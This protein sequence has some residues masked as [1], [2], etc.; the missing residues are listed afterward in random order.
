VAENSAAG[1]LVGRVAA[2]DPDANSTLTYTL[3]NDAGGRFDINSAT[4][5]VTVKAGA[6][7]DFEAAA[8]HSIR[9]EAKDAGGSAAFA[10]L[11]VKVGNVNEAPTI[12]SSAAAGYSEN[13]TTAVYQAAAID[14]E[15]ATLTWS[16][17]GAD[18]SLFTIGANGA[19]SFKA[20]PNFEAPADAGG[21]NV[22]D[23]VVNA[24][25]GVNTAQK[26]V[27]ISVTNVN[28][29]PSV[30]SGASASFAEN[31]SGVVYQG[32]AVDPDSGSSLSWSLSGADAS[33]FAI[34]AA[35]GQVTFKSPPNFEMPADQG[36]NNIY[37]VVVTASDGSLGGSQAVQISVTNVNEAPSA[38]SWAVSGLVAENAASGS[39]VGRATS[40]DPDAAQTLSYTLVNNAGG[41]FVIN[42]VTG[43][44]SVAAGASFDFETATSH[45]IR[46]RA[47]DPQ[48]LNSEADL[49][50]AVSDVN[51]SPVITSAASATFNE[52]ATGAAYIVTAADPDAGTTLSYGLGG[53]DAAL[54]TINASTGQVSFKTSP[55][56]E[57]PADANA[58]NVYEVT[59]S[60][61]DGILTTTKAV[62]IAVQNVNEAPIVTSASSANF[63]ENGTGV[64]YTA[65]GSDVD[66]G[67]TLSFSLTGADSALF[68]INSASG[69]VTFKA[70][71]NFESPT[72][73]G[74]DNVYDIVITASDGQ[75]SASKT[76]AL[77]VT[78]INEAPTVTSG[79]SA[80]FSENATGVAYT[81]VASDP[82]ALSSFS[83]KIDGADAALFDVNAAT[84]Q[85]SFK[86]P[87][88]FE[89]P[90]DANGDN[91]Y[92]VSVTVT[93]QGGLSATKAVQIIVQNVNEAPVIT[94]GPTAMFAENASGL[95]YDA[96]ATD[97][98]AGT[99][100]VYS[101]TGTDA[102]LFNIDPTSG[103][104]TFKTPPNFEA[105]SD[106]GA[107]NVYDI[108]VHASDGS[109]S[110]N[111]AVSIEVTNVN[112]APTVTSAGSLSV[113]ENVTG[114]IYT[115]TATD[116]DTGATVTYSVS[117]TDSS[118]FTI[119]AVTGEVAFKNSPNFEAP[120]DQNSDNIYD[121]TIT[122]S[123]GQLTSS[124]QL[125]I[126]VQDVVEAPIFSS[127]VA[128]AVAENSSGVAY[129]AV[130]TG[131]MG[132]LTYSL[133][134]GGD[135]N[136][137]TINAT[138]GQVTF[139]NP[140][141]F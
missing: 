81:I 116:P 7:L 10:D 98:D 29:A 125:L 133:A 107:N 47:T 49:V 111:R 106:G 82:D 4:G 101:L 119:N 88:D 129:T 87:P 68:N 43:E 20:S 89:A 45:T 33:L 91:V 128:G 9:V 123:D 109:L 108:V 15:G 75:L 44:V 64:V 37:D 127:G 50:V 21:N 61:S 30:T 36:G 69:Q 92:A 94:S 104:V 141:N 5:D 52:M 58:D 117:G 96:N 65:T 1:A 137:F 51:E 124:K 140:A 131:G 86:T 83:Y 11:L 26:A 73:A 113:N 63:A 6:V 130:A 110:K 100:L 39:V 25:D 40:V 46:V 19:V 56:F 70:P 105:P 31:G 22:Y 66:A 54:F 97:P 135:N 76:V 14:P 90:V 17:S 67:T 122:A 57:A 38:P 79:A 74:A 72:D 12:T 77:K 134:A 13:G 59:V 24:S 85:I 138:N 18:A 41:R 34:N 136:L 16:L 3:L 78:D 99:S 48:N 23:I 95:V 80:N 132:T 102:A 42:A 93:D 115:A 118:Q 139:K 60:A 53:A 28:E 103:V 120:S 62:Q 71:P 121:I 55:N 32:T 112:E 27:A 114:A 126:Q 35:T 2:V 84:G 8:T